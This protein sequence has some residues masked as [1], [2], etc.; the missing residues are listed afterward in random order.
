MPI[1]PGL[2]ISG[3]GNNWTTNNID[4]FGSGVTFDTMTDV[5]TNTNATTANYCVLN[6][7]N[8]DTTTISNGNLTGAVTGSSGGSG[9]FGTMALPPSSKIYAEVF[10]TSTGDGTS[11]GVTSDTSSIVN[12][13]NNCLAYIFSGNKTVL[14]TDS[15]YGASYT[16]NDVIGIAVDTG[17]GTIEFFKN[18]TS[19]G[20]LTNS[21]IS[22]NT[23]FF[24]CIYFS[25]TSSSNHSWNFGQ[26]PFA[27]TPPSGFVALN[28]F[29]LPTPTIGATASTLANRYMDATTYTAN[30][31]SQTITNSGSMQPDLVWTKRRDSTSNHLLIDSVRGVGLNLSTNST[32]AQVTDSVYLTSFNSNGFSIGTGN[33]S[34]GNTMIAWQWNAGGTTVTNTSGTI[35]AQ[36][37]ANTTSGFSVVTYTGTGS[38]ATVGH[39]LGVA[40][41]WVICKRRNSTGGWPI[42]VRALNN[43]AQYMTLNTTDGANT[44]ST[45]FNNT[46]PTSS[47]FSLGTDTF[48]NANGGTYVAYC[49]AAVA[50]YSSFGRYT[51]TGSS[52]GAFVYTGFRPRYVMFMRTDTTGG[53][54]MVDS[55]RDPFNVAGQMLYAYGTDAE[56]TNP[57]CDLVSNG[58]KVRGTSLF[59]NASGGTYIYMAFAESPFNY[60][61]AR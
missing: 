45:V 24:T 59:M 21:V 39:G 44:D 52:D 57:Y 35:S 3:N 12:A 51:G 14:G 1:N 28:T 22:S 38:A 46:A 2:D 6:P 58:F 17:A 42:F 5:P 47:V 37:R 41:S 29:N 49:F 19:Q 18:N 23:M 13:R 48:A 33:Y 26:R 61:N 7:L 30:G 50:G 43:N 53:A 11:F 36:V 15:G 16:A 9:Y 60:A 25:S 4:W 54:A 56:G 40:P 8:V 34:N 10:V 27:Y 32:A 20:V 31:T 55:S